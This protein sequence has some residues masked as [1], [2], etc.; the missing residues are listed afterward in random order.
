MRISKSGGRD[1]ALEAPITEAVAQRKAA[2]DKATEEADDVSDIFGLVVSVKHVA[3]EIRHVQGRQGDLEFRFQGNLV[4]SCS[5]P[6]SLAAGSS[7][8]DQPHA[9]ARY[10]TRLQPSSEDG[11]R[12]STTIGSSQVKCVHA[13]C[14]YSIQEPHGIPCLAQPCRAKDDTRQRR[15]TPRWPRQRSGVARSQCR[16]RQR[17]PWWRGTDLLRMLREQPGKRGL[18]HSHVGT[19]GR[20]HDLE[21]GSTLMQENAVAGDNLE[22]QPPG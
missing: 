5:P 12:L 20:I 15:P 9:R 16:R 6:G 8:G 1:D 2:A 14:P 19:Q 17:R 3:I 7:F 10:A 11:L 22:A 4:Q 13:S 18:E 21:A